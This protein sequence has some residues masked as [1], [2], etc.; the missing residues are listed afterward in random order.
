M[1]PAK[2]IAAT[3]RH[4]QRKL[5]IHPHD[6]A[7]DALKRNRWSNIDLKSATAICRPCGK[8]GLR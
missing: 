6:N 8:K 7:K 2:A 3:C 1:K 5:M 4:C